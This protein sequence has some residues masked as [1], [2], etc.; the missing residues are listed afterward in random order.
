MLYNSTQ[1]YYRLP[2]ILHRHA[3]AAFFVDERE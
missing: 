1:F 3:V 2:E